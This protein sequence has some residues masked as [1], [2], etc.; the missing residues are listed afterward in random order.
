MK[1]KS[2]L[3]VKGL[4]NK[5]QKA[6]LILRFLKEYLEIRLANAQP[7]SLD[8]DSANLL[9]LIPYGE[10]R[11][12][13]WWC[14]FYISRRQPFRDC[15]NKLNQKQFFVARVTKIERISG[16]LPPNESHLETFECFCN[17]NWH[18]GVNGHRF[19]LVHTTAATAST[20]SLN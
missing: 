15:F 1:N 9:K 10:K 14:E 4:F 16:F 7:G 12:G 18:I 6:F 20:L 19:A 13:A 3:L 5:L 8:D 2:L 11:Q 17:Y